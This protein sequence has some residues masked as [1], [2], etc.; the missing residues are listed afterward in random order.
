VRLG[1]KDTKLGARKRK[2][3]LPATPRGGNLGVFTSLG[4]EYTVT[5][6]K[7][8]VADLEKGLTFCNLS[9]P[10]EKGGGGRGKFFKEGMSMCR[11][12]KTGGPNPVRDEIG[13]RD[14]QLSSMA[15]KHYA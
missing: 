15:Q 3:P 4:G 1:G 9:K 12:Q 13:Q 6:R 5:T 8:N 14:S 10:A 7:K 11:G 2:R